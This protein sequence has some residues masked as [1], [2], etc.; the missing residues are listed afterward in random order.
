VSRHSI[1]KYLKHDDMPSYAAAL[2][3]RAL[4]ALFPFS[5]LLVALLGILEVVD[6]FDWL[7]GHT[8]RYKSN[9]QGSGS[10]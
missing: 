3:Y 6:F 8:P 1:R 4:F 10:R 2:A 7:I 5:A 9:T